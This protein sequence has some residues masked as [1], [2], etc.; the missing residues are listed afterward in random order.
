MARKSKQ[1]EAI[2]RVLK[3]TTSH[4]TAEQIY[5]Q[6]RK[7]IPNISLGTV[8][9]NLKLLK[10]EGRI[11]ELDIIG[12]F[13][14]Y[15]G[16]TEN[17]SHF[18]CEQCGNI[19]DLDEPVDRELDERVSRKMGFKVSNHSLVFHGLCKDCQSQSRA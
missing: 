16:K 3:E 13:S 11:S 14:R 19:F 6:V 1:R 12:A 5:K 7:E 17:H 9:R 15:D 2:L 10:Q 4:P 8:Y 18:I